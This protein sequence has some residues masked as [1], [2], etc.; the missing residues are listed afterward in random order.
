MRTIPVP[1]SYTSNFYW[2]MLKNLS[3]DVKL[4]LISRLSVSLLKKE[5]RSESSNWA[6]QFA[7]AWKDDRTADEIVEDIRSARTTNT[8]IEL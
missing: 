4:E 1:E 6:S 2:N 5:E 7:G 3:S 8:G